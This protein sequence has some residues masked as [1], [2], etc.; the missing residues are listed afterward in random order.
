MRKV[1]FFLLFFL[2]AGFNSVSY[3]QKLSA[4]IYSG[5]NFSD[6]HGQDINGKWKS[7]PGPSEVLNVGYSF[8][9][10]F[11]IQTGFT[12]S[13]VYYEYKSDKLYSNVFDILNISII[14]DPTYPVYYSYDKIMD[15]SFLRIPLLLSVSIPNALQF[16]MKAGMFLSFMQ[17]YSLQT[18]TYSA[19]NVPQP[20][21][22][23]FGYMF[24]SGVAYPFNKSF[25]AAFNVSYLTG[26]KTFIEGSGL[27]HGSSEYTLGIVYTGFNNK[28]AEQRI[29]IAD[30]DSVKKVTVSLRSG[31]NL[32][33]NTGMDSKKYLPYPGPS[34]GFSIDF[35]LRGGYFFQ[36]GFSFDRKGY[37]LKDSSTTFYR[38]TRDY[39]TLYYVNTRTIIDY[40][41]VPALICFPL[42][43][44]GRLFLNTGPWI[45]LKLNARNIGTAFNSTH[46]GTSY[47][48]KKTVIYN[49]IEQL[50]QNYDYGW[51]MGCESLWPI[52]NGRSDINVTL[53][54]SAGLR[55]V[56][57]SQKFSEN[58][59]KNS[60]ASAVIQNGTLSFIIGI[61]IPSNNYQTAR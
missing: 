25:K 28:K 45:G 5:V 34:L 10:T 38:V 7:K 44:S 22:K 4:G 42:G 26:R 6:I 51:V 54:Y 58:D 47:T 3:S 57:N 39:N 31:L 1:K 2:I 60:N 50:V 12:Y 41:V 19:A 55:Q 53:Q 17:D 29:P 49:D 56:Y 52:L 16:N 21:K 13:S 20:A 43:R 23:D 59:G 37:S 32:S 61:K 46:A 15:F 8:N 35:P 27:R 18:Y 36:T 14:G 40:A 24:S 30:H 33:L 11:G 48:L 9:R